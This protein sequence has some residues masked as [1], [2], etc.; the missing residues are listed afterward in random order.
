MIR[1]LGASF[2]AGDVVGCGLDYARRRIFFVKNGE[3]LG[4]AFDVLREDVIERGLFPTVGVDT[5]CPLFVNFGEKPFR[6]DLSG[7]ARE[8]CQVAED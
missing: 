6:F 7:F 1:S 5:E 2:G 3:F 4:Y 8:G